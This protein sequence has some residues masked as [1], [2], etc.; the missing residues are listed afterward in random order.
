MVAFSAARPGRAHRAASPDACPVTALLGT[1]ATRS[2]ARPDL[3]GP[4]ATPPGGPPEQP[5]F[6]ITLPE[7]S[8]RSRRLAAAQGGRGGSRVSAGVP[9]AAGRG[10]AGLRPV[11][12]VA[13]GGLAAA[14]APRNPSARRLRRGPRAGH[15]LGRSGAEHSS[16]RLQVARG[17]G[18]MDARVDQDRVVTWGMVWGMNGGRSGSQKVLEAGSRDGKCL[19]RAVVHAV[20]RVPKPCVAGSIP[21]G[22]ALWSPLRSLGRDDRI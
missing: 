18:S 2:G 16:G 19:A 12:A 9:R 1:P 13:L 11:G 8:P 15:C 17:Y 5:A 10:A 7:P 20:V 4:E 3:V 14:P 22:G 6:C 21:A